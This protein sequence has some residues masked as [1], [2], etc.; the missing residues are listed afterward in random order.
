MKS[1]FLKSD[2]DGITISYALHCNACNFPFPSNQLNTFCTQ[3]GQSPIEVRYDLNKAIPKEIIEHNERSMWR[4]A[5]L[6]P[7]QNSEHIVSLG[8]GWTP[9]LAVARLAYDLG[10]ANLFLKDE[11]FNPTGSFKARGL[12]MAVSRA[13]E[14]GVRSMIVPTAGNAGG[15]LSA[16]CAKAGME[17]IVVMPRHTPDAFKKECKAF[18]AELI[19][20]DGLI[21]DCAQLVA[22]LK[23]DRRSF[24]V[25]TMKEPYRLEGK[26]TLG[27]EI[28]EQM[29]WVL[30]DV[31]LYPA[32][33]GTGLIGIWKAFKEMLSMGWITNIPTRMIAVQAENCKP[34]VDT[35]S[36]VQVNS[37]NY[38]GRATIANGLAVP[39]PFAEKM[40]LDV[41]QQS[42]GT[43]LAVSEQEIINSVKVIAAKEGMLVAPEGAALLAALKIL[44]GNGQVSAEEKILLLNT[45]SCYKYLDNFEF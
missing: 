38:H 29:N 25:S 17:A 7:V 10:V 26:K 30:P 34:L 12:S 2:S 39:R 33:G 43:T 20:V 32:G 9:I 35:F 6:L 16:Y 24:D 5:R 31:I 11:S 8:E 19:L 44:L 23:L 37:S 13:K 27:Y 3:C 42:N 41:L 14:L 4:Y 22:K 1:S 36:K 21:N 40:M 18:G 45:G 28:A 15:A